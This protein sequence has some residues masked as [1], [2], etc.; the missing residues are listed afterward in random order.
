MDDLATEICLE[1]HSPFQLTNEYE[2]NLIKARAKEF[3][4]ILNQQSHQS[5][6]TGTKKW[7]IKV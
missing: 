5:L 7:S 6:P 1:E 2:L 3:Y 4:W